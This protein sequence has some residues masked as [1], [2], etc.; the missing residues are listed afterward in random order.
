MSLSIDIVPLADSLDM[1]G[2]P[3][4]SSAFSLSGHVS[5][6]LSS[7]FSVFERRRAARVILH[8]VQI[9]FEGQT[10][11]LTTSLGYSPLRLYS[12]EREL[13]ASSEPIELSNDDQEETDEPCR[14]NVVFDLP[15]PGWLPAS[16]DFASGDVGASTKYF[17]QALVKFAVVEDQRATSW[18]FST[19][20]SP[21]RPSRI[22]SIETC[23][24]ITLRRFVEPPTDEPTPPGLVNYLLSAPKPS[25]KTK[26]IPSDI[27]SKI[28]VLASVPEHVDVCEDNVPFTL[29][30]R[31]KDLEDGDCERLQVTSFTVDVVQEEICRRVRQ[32]SEYQ[33]RYPIPSQ[34]SQ[35]PN[36]PLISSHHMRDMYTLGL[37]LA[38]SANPN[39][40][41]CSTSLLPPGETGTYHLSGG[42]RI[43]ANDAVNDTATWYTMETTIPF[44]QNFPPVDGASDWEGASKVRPSTASPLYDVSHSLKLSLRCEYEIPDS[45]EPVVADL[46]FIVPLTFGR[47]APPLPP[48]DILPALFHSMCLPDGAYP[49]MP[50]LLPYGANLPVYSQLFDSHGNR[51]MDATPLP[52]YTPRS[53]SD[54]PVDLPSSNEKQ[55]EL[56]VMTV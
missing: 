48:R 25:N 1:Y 9:T 45:T 50:S 19:F 56:Q 35:P 24:A 37:F 8:S 17:L 51:K 26:D 13:L 54:S 46:K 33:M 15:I 36:K 53:S 44:I 20:C 11:T 6:T 47:I 16:H 30:L 40:A 42:N 27:F 31:T 34:D 49:P 22:R 39:R 28:Q 12:L 3:Q 10:E 43:F 18:S 55:E 7:P 23:K 41:M 2:D 32:A 21:F 52:L 5:I 29:R 14:W 4:S 38:P